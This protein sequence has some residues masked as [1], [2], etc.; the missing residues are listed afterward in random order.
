M[1][2]L[3]LLAL[4]AFL[5]TFTAAHAQVKLGTVDMNKVFTEYYKTKDAETKLNEAR[6]QAKKEFDDRMERLKKN[7]DEITKFNEDINKPELSKE[8]KAELQKQLDEKMTETRSLD[9][10]TAEFR[11]TRERQLQDQFMRM[12]K[13]IID[14]IMKVVN[15]RVKSTGYDLVLDKSGVSLGQVPVVLYA[16]D[17]L[18]FSASIITELNKNAPKDLLNKAPAASKPAAK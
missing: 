11:Q 6:A 5:T 12:R 7:M 14:D 8:K 15:E 13:D 4:A 10:N 18:D 1:R 16:R 9:Q 2:K 17:D 3:S